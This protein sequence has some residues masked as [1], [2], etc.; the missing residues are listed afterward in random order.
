MQTRS[1]LVL[2]EEAES[3]IGVLPSLH[4]RPNSKN[5]RALIKVSEERLQGIPAYQSLRYGYRGFITPA[6][7]YALTGEPQWVDYQDP[8][9]YRALGGNTS[10]HRDVDV[11]FTVALNIYNIQ[12]NVR[13]LSVPQGIKRRGAGGTSKGAGRHGPRHIYSHG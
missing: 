5:M 12:E 10:Q 4:S 6:A 9:W 11:Q 3:R 13:P 7:V 2:Y 1:K 8:G